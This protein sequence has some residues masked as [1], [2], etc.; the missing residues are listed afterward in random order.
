MLA[1]AGR[2]NATMG[3]EVRW[4]GVFLREYLLLVW[5]VWT[6]AEA[7]LAA[8][9]SATWAAALT[10]VAM[11]IVVMIGFKEGALVAA[12]ADAWGYV[13][14]ADRWANGTL[15]VEQPL[16][17]E[18]TPTLPADV[19]APLAYRPSP[20]GT[21]IVPM[22]S[23][24]LPMVM[25][26]FQVIGGRDAVF[27][28][29]P[30]LAGVAIVGTYLLGRG[31]SGPGTGVAAAML[32][33]ASPSFLFQL[34]SSPMS[35]IPATAWWALSL[36]TVLVPARWAA[37]VSG[38]AAG[39]AVLT[40][41]NLAPLAAAPAALLLIAAWRERHVSPA[42]MQRVALFLAGVLPSFAIVAWLNSFW[43]GSPLTSGYGAL[44]DLFRWEHIGANLQRYPRWLLESQTPLVLL[45]FAA[46]WFVR[47]R[48]HAVMLIAFV[49]G[50]LFA[51]LPYFPFDAWWFL[52]FLL[53]AYPP[54]L[55][56]T[57]ATLVH[58]ARR[59]PVGLCGAVP[60]A[61]IVLTMWH[62]VTYAAARATFDSDGEWKYAIAGRYVAEHLP[63]RAVLLAVQHS[64]SAR[65]YSGR[66][67]IRWD[68]VPADKLEWMLAEVERL[69][70]VPYALMEDWEEPAMRERFA[71][72]PAALLL[73]RKPLAELP[74]GN[75]RIYALG[76][77][78]QL[79]VGSGQ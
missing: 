46:P 28:V 68:W 15:R 12:S 10:F 75:V 4:L 5:D 67:T 32:L 55:A 14:Q 62:G 8:R 37:F 6:R 79:A 60:I 19:L 64:G 48:A 61:A 7:A 22:V 38:A 1:P 13:S 35:D 25:A 59:F 57:A 26:L 78:R 33:A 2:R 70:Y 41:S 49:M 3:R 76:S 53:P 72:R 58:A 77:S 27:A 56:L 50:T 45:A 51:Y 52:R 47:R 31:L 42:G 29:V 24:G 65:Y 34:T 39:A 54:L 17:R 63:E 21:T 74:L 30:L 11:T 69:G 23:P 43:Y 66:I 36:A 16:M 40:R 9:G 44:G 71:G 20:D 73:D 18:L